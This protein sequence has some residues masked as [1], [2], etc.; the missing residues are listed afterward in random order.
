MIGGGQTV[1]PNLLSSSCNL[2]LFWFGCC[3]K[4]GGYN[5]QCSKMLLWIT[6]EMVIRLIYDGRGCFRSENCELSGIYLIQF[7]QDIR[8][9]FCLKSSSQLKY[10][11]L[12]VNIDILYE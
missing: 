6:L 11:L 10:C 2:F 7:L 1:I 12:T 3:R 4:R 8:I 5:L 9:V